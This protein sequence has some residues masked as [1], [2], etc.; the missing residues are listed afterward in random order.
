M[1]GEYVG[2]LLVLQSYHDKW[3]RVCSILWQQLGRA[4]LCINYMGV[5]QTRSIPLPTP[6]I[7]FL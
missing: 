5:L 7:I 2:E 3:L 1:Y 6:S 4:E